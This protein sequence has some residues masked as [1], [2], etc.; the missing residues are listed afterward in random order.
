MRLLKRYYF[1]TIFLFFA[2]ANFSEA[3]GR[4]SSNTSKQQSNTELG[5]PISIDE[6]TAVVEVQE[7]SLLSGIFSSGFTVSLVLLILLVFSVGTWAIIGTKLMYLKRT[8]LHHEEF[9]EDFWNSKSLNDFHSA[10]GSKPYSPARDAFSEGYKELT[11]I[12]NIKEH[13]ITKEVFLGVA[14]TNLSRTLEKAKGYQRSILE[15]FLF[16][17]AIVASSAPFIGLFGTVW[18][19]MNAFAGIARTG[20]ASLTA[21]APGISEALIATAFGL[22]AAIPASIGYNYCV[23][24]IRS[25][26][27]SLDHFNHDFL[28]LVERHLISQEGSKSSRNVSIETNE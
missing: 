9:L 1:I 11:K 21:V 15:R 28:N 14:M 2:A 20:N 25:L 6:E 27:I 19:I 23:V 10:V 26:L 12:N 4:T 7:R 5:T 13:G 8:K 17:L 16:L 24:R 18:G 22:A 3:S